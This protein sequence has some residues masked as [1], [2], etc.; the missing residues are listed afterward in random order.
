MLQRELVQQKR[1]DPRLRKWVGPTGKLSWINTDDMTFFSKEQW[2]DD[3]KGGILCEEM[4]TGKTVT[5]SAT[6]L[7]VVHFTGI[8]YDDT[9]SKSITS[10]R[11]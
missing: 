5:S 8:D 1:P 3:I 6:N 4:G 7:T 2:V 9:T 10:T 11:D